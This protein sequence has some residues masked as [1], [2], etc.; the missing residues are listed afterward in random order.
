V[1]SG[2]VAVIASAVMA[3]MLSAE[4]TDQQGGCEIALPAQQ[5]LRA[6]AQ[7]RERCEQ[8]DDDGRERERA[9]HA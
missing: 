5:R 4:T 6:R 3:A 9:R 7:L 8:R 1:P 2:A